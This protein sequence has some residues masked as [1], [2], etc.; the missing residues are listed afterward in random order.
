MSQPNLLISMS[1]KKQHIRLWYECLQICLGDK[2]YSDN[3]NKSKDFYSDWGDVKNTKFDHWWR[4]NKILFKDVYVMEVDRVEKNPNTMTISIPINE[5]ITTIV[6]EIKR[7]V[8]N[9]QK[10]IKNDKGLTKVNYQF[11]A[12]EIKGIFHYIN[13]EVYKIFIEMLSSWA[14]GGGVHCHTNDKPDF[15]ISK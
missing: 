4:Q 1:H 2:K 6:S 5:K 14:A 10:Q 11:S 15:P 13:L 3:L 9:K 8:G 7:I 12:K